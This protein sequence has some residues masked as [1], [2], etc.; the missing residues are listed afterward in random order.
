ICG[1]PSNLKFALAYLYQILKIR[2]PP[3]IEIILPKHNL[4]NPSSSSI[5]LEQLAPN[6]SI[7]LVPQ[8]WAAQFSK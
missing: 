3:L 8:V 2:V 5:S 1:S 7:T 6:G 4:I